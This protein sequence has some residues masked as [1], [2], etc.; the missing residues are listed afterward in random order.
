MPEKELL[1]ISVNISRAHLSN[2]GLP[3]DLRRIAHKHGVPTK[4]LEIELTES[5][6]FENLEEVGAL[7]AQLKKDGFLLAID[8]FG[9]GYSSLA[10]LK[11]LPADIVKMDKSFLDEAEN[12]E[13]GKRIIIGMVR[14]IKSLNMIT[15]A[16]G[17][18]TLAQLE[19]LRN[20]GCDVVQ[21]YYHARPM[22]LDDYEKLL[23]SKE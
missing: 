22:P 4:L 23:M 5:A 14:M 16:E 12:D 21:G 1:P 7:M 6:V 3:E 13:R 2:P 15:L 20:A 17:V 10:S 18:E 8:D 9:S 19:M 11:A